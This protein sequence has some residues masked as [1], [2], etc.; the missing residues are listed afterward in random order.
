MIKV[1]I[2]KTL[3]IYGILLDLPAEI[4]LAGTLLFS[5]SLWILWGMFWFPIIDWIFAQLA[6]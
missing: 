3:S 5:F 1:T 4:A 2:K 6:G